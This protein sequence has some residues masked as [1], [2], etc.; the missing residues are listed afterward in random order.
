LTIL[1]PLLCFGKPLTLGEMCETILNLEGK[2]NYQL[3]HDFTP[4]S[5]SIQLNGCGGMGIV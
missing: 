3:C 4:I 5:Q 2:A 1:T